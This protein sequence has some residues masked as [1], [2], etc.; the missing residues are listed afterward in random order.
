[1]SNQFLK[2]SDD[3][4]ALAFLCKLLQSSTTLTISIF[5]QCL[6][7]PPQIN[8]S[9]FTERLFLSLQNIFSNVYLERDSHAYSKECQFSLISLFML[10][11]LTGNNFYLLQ[12]LSN[13][14]PLSWLTVPK[15]TA[16]V[17]VSIALSREDSLFWYRILKNTNENAN[18]ENFSA[19]PYILVKH[20]LLFM[21]CNRLPDHI[22]QANCLISYPIL[23]LF[24]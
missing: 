4:E 24:E 22:L 14:L 2:A 18:Q 5:S 7:L 11:S 8:Y 13:W 9:F 19:F 1:M 6:D 10:H 21:I 16:P 15:L 17:K 3:R 23:Y 20:S 12:T